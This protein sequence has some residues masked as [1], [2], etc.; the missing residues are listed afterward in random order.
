M[1]LFN[2]RTSD[3]ESLAYMIAWRRVQ[4]GRHWLNQHAPI[5]WHRGL[6]DVRGK[7]SVSFRCW[8]IDENDCVLALAFESCKQFADSNG[9]VRRA[10]I[11][12]HFNL[13]S[14]RMWALGFDTQ[15]RE[16]PEADRA[17]DRV[18]EDVLYREHDSTT[19]RHMLPYE[20]EYE[21]VMGYDFTEKKPNFF[22]KLFWKV[23]RAFVP[24]HHG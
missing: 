22:Q 7:N 14:R 11:Q 1:S 10:L 13:S 15:L 8:N 5:N 9:Y 4:R 16:P 18:W 21:R 19:Y 20:E 2:L 17:L 24:S 23:R 12:K 6:F 3:P